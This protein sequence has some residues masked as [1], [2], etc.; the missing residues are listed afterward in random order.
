MSWTQTE[1][2]GRTWQGSHGD[3]HTMD[4]N[5]FERAIRHGHP[6]EHD[7]GGVWLE[8]H[9]N[10]PGWPDAKAKSWPVTTLHVAMPEGR[11][12]LYPALRQRLQAAV[13]AF[14]QEAQL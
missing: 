3:L 1:V 7:D 10:Y 4:R 14:I 8:E 6:E 5:R 9:H 11:E 13:D 2:A 12:D